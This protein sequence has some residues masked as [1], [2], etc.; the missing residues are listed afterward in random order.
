MP[1]GKRS[2]F[3]DARY[4]GVDIQYAHDIAGHMQVRV[5]CSAH[6][7]RVTPLRCCTH[8][9][10]ASA[11]S[12]TNTQHFTTTQQNNRRSTCCVALT[13]LWRRWLTQH[14]NSRR[15]QATQSIPALP[16]SFLP[17]CA[18]S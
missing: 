14:T 12:L 2:E 8:V 13:L 15:C 10:S 1:L 9:S 6:T 5:G 4:A 3:G 16:L 18:Q 7:K 17:G 11:F